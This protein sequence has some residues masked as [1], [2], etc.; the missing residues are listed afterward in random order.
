M[1]RLLSSVILLV[2]LFAVSCSTTVS[3][4]YIQP[5][6]IDMGGYR[7]LAVA[8][9]VP[10]RGFVPYTG[11]IPGRDI[12]ASRFHI[13][14]GYSYSVVSGVA[15]YATEEL[16][17]T[18]LNS[19]FFNL[20]SP[21][22]TDAILDRGS[23]GYD[24]SEEFRAL[25]YD[26]V[27]IPRIDNM[28]V[29]EYIYSE[30]YEEWW[31]DSEGR[32]HRSIEYEYYYRQTASITYTLTLIDTETGSIVTR[33][34]FTD[35]RYRE[36][37][38]DPIWSRLDDPG[39]LFRRMLSSFNEGILRQFV[40]RTRVYDVTLMNNKPKNES[41]EIAYKYA[42]DGN[43][44][45]A[46]AVFQDVWE[47]SQ[48]LPSGYNAALFI[49]S[50]GKY[51]EALDLLLEIQNLYSDEKVRSL[52]RDIMTI[53]SRNEEGVGQITGSSSA[54]EAKEHNDNDVYF[55]VLNR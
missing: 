39:Y 29:D 2:L 35:S 43:T 44:A 53:R 51:D 18:L 10:Y 41:A 22:R 55:A 33:R 3:I 17:S 36:N 21:S 38:F 6:V 52:Y 40:P 49:A 47:S 48:H 54:V 14:T 28:S 12:Y 5:S 20:L 50:Q 11:W 26:A 13:R 7:N 42:K 1:R 23:Y 30:P 32:R 24:I 15:E 31:T 34:T 16:Y 45:S 27:L 4:P 25:G 37:S 8:S 19:G 46:L 9:A